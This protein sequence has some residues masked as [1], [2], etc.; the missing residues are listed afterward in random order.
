MADQKSAGNTACTTV[1]LN[2]L[3]LSPRNVRKTNAKEDIES[4]ADS[5]S[6]KGLLQNLVVSPGAGKSGIYEVDAGGRRYHALQLLVERKTIARNFPV[7]VL[8]VPAADATEASLAENLQKIAMN[9]ADEVEAF[10]AIVDRYASGGI[11]DR[12]AQVANCARRFGVTVRYVEQRLRLAALAPEILAALREGRITLDAAKAYSGHPDQKL[13]LKVFE[14]EEKKGQWGHGPLAIRDAIRGKT[15]PSD[16]RAVLYVGID[17]Y[18]AA[19]GRV[20]TDLF[21]GAEEREV[22]LDPAIVDRLVAE[23]A[24]AEAAALAQ[25]SGFADGALRPWNRPTYADPKAPKGFQATWREPPA[26][27]RAEA[28]VAFEIAEDGSGLKPI[29]RWLVKAEGKPAATYGRESEKQAAVRD[30]KRKVDILA[31]RLA[32]PPIAG[33]P[34][35]G[36]AY[37]PPHDGLVRTFD[38]HEDGGVVIVMLIKVA[39]AD[40]A[41]LREQAE[42]QLADEAAAAPQVQRE[43]ETPAKPEVAEPE[44]VL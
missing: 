25:E 5:I 37:W 15:Y 26:E 18:A 41:A 40:V 23:K 35:E 6:A 34:L 19:G 14:A 3:I 17:A 28:L 8:I 1:P 20:A 12:A 24:T 4:L 39:E 27:Q 29:G 32:V 9:P 11:V 36:R 21:M 2:K 30:H 16:H 31:A 42:W 43:P 22:L 38:Q 33:T 44:P 13:Q 10:A 7:P